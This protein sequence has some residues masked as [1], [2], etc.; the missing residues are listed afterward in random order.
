MEVGLGALYG[1][2]F[3]DLIYVLSIQVNIQYLVFYRTSFL[4]YGQCPPPSTCLLTHRD[5]Q[6][7]RLMDA[8]PWRPKMALLFYMG[9]WYRSI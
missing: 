5:S 6:L 8:I 9:C 4:E 1:G 3:E 7:H 2:P